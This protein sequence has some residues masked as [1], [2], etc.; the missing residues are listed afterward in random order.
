VHSHFTQ[1]DLLTLMMALA[2]PGREEQNLI[3]LARR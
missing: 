3:K 1:I 2:R